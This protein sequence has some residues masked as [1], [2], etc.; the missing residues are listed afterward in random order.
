MSIFGGSPIENSIIQAAASQ[1][2]A[3]RVR[4]RERAAAERAQRYADS[5]DLRITGTDSPDAVR[6]IPGNDSE[7][8]DQERKGR[9]HQPRQD[10]SRPRLDV[11]A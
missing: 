5:V 1:E 6:S 2:A 8:A 4:D 3:S 9:K 10:A 11:M 7:Q